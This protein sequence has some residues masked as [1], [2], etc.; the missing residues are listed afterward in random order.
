MDDNA[1]A[2]GAGRTLLTVVLAVLAGLV[3]GWVGGLFVGGPI[4]GLVGE[5]LGLDPMDNVMVGFLSGL[6]IFSLASVWLVLYLRDASLFTR[7]AVLIMLAIAGSISAGA[8]VYTPTFGK[9]LREPFGPPSGRLQASIAGTRE[10]AGEPQRSRN[11]LSVSWTFR[12]GMT[13]MVGLP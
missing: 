5:G 2:G 4:G 8:L 12:P 7:R 11:E 6:A 1:K 3:G 10:P 9:D 13:N